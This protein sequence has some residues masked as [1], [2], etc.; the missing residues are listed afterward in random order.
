MATRYWVGGTGTWDASATTHWSASSGG[1]SGASVPTSL[2]DVVFNGSSGAGTCTVGARVPCKTLVCTGYTGTLDASANEIT[3]YGSVTLVSGMTLAANSTFLMQASG[4]FTSGGKTVGYLYADAGTTTLGDN[5][6][7]LGM[8]YNGS[9]SGGTGSFDLNGKT[10]NLSGPLDAS[11][12]GSGLTLNGATVNFSGSGS[13][14]IGTSGL[15]ITLGTGTA[16]FKFT[17]SAAS[18][19][20]GGK[21]W[22][23]VWLAIPSGD[24]FTL[25][26][27]SGTFAD[28]KSDA[29]TNV[30]FKNGKTFTATTFTFTGTAGN[31]ITMR[32]TS[33]GSRYTLSDSSGTNTFDYCDIKDCLASGG[34]TFRA[35]HSINSGNNS[36]IDFGA[37]SFNRTATLTYLRR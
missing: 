30:N 13:Q 36:G 27:N 37:V 25:D 18:A 5:L 10:V 35:T 19:D 21:T 12:G 23:N 4:T 28:L 2:D 16:T 24:S 9:G 11:G 6:T 14:L 20:F 34:A 33:A 7:V 26:T 15:T 22:G 17:G 31:R 3:P 32:S 1:S 29:N 8:G